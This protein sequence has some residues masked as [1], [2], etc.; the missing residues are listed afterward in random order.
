MGLAKFWLQLRE[1][2]RIFWDSA[3]VVATNRLLSFNITSQVFASISAEFE[4]NFPRKSLRRFTSLFLFVAKWQEFTIKKTLIRCVPISVFFL[5]KISS[6]FKIL[7]PIFVF[8]NLGYFQLKKIVPFK[9]SSIPSTSI[10]YNLGCFA[11]YL[12]K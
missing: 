1:G 3:Y 6:T 10:Y 2:G 4:H 7:D 12:Y 5:E 11:M 8:F 9:I